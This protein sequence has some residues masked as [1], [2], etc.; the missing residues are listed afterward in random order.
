MY[1]PNPMRALAIAIVCFAIPIGAATNDGSPDEPELSDAANDVSYD[2]AYVGPK[3]HEYLD[4]RAAWFSYNGASNTVSLT[5]RFEELAP[6]WDED[7]WQIQYYLSANGTVGEDV[8][9]LLEYRLVKSPPGDDWTA[10]LTW[11]SGAN[12]NL[13]ADVVVLDEFLTVERVDP[14]EMVFTVDVSRLRELAD[15]LED[16]E[17]HA[18]EDERPAEYGFSPMG[19]EDRATSNSAYDLTAVDEPPRSATPDAT[20]SSDPAASSSDKTST[21]EQ[22]SDEARGT[23]GLSMVAVIASAGVAV[24]IR[25]RRR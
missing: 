2:A 22:G 1:A 20:A 23:P 19:G 18:F 11:Y 9:G 14:D 17:V 21:V 12:G 6:M 10:E 16:L 4:V 24:A 8:R 7:G 15:R 5:A 13:S 3:D 25:S